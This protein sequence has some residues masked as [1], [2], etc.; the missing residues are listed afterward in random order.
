MIFKTNSCARPLPGLR[1]RLV[2][3]LHSPR[4]SGLRIER[5]FS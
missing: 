5:T 2:D 4:R 1:I 3:P